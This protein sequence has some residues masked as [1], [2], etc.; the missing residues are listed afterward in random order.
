MTYF[1]FYLFINIWH[2][3]FSKFFYDITIFEFSL[4]NI[5]FIKCIIVIYLL[6]NILLSYWY[7]LYVH[8]SNI[9]CNINYII[10]VGNIPCNSQISKCVSINLANPTIGIS[11][12]GEC[13]VRVVIT[14]SIPDWAYAHD[15]TKVPN[16]ILLEAYSAS[17]IPIANTW[18]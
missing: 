17:T 14:S 7:N 15:A 8:L 16:T 2:N 13:N 1:L 6:L 18:T 3:F 5:K 9:Y 10:C 11:D 4:I 12:G